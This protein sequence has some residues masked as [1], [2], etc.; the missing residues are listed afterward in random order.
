MM[1]P[2]ISDLQRAV[3]DAVRAYTDGL[4]V[5]TTNEIVRADDA[6]R[7]SADPHPDLRPYF[8]AAYL[9][10]E[11]A[12]RLSAATPKDGDKLEELNG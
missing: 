6:L 2:E 5:T 9:K 11:Q 1:K 3:L 8:D 10:A 7:A 4:P 12:A